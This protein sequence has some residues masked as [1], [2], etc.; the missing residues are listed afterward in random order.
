MSWLHVDLE[1]LFGAFRRRPG[2]M[3]NTSDKGTST[4]QRAG[5]QTGTGLAQA[6]E[7]VDTRM[8]IEA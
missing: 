1:V 7:L 8:T 5:E 2:K 3:A 6:I 4:S